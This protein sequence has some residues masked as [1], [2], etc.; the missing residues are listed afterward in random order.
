MPK[1]NQI[2]LLVSLKHLLN[3]FLHL[4]S[5]LTM[6]IEEV[7][8]TAAGEYLKTKYQELTDQMQEQKSVIVSLK[9]KEM[10]VKEF[11][12]LSVRLCSFYLTN[13]SCDMF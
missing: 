7:G 12:R 6:E 1:S 11:T 2:S 9:K 3:A 10:K 8:Q 13:C 4:S 5:V